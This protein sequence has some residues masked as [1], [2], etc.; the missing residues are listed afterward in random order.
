M[1][2]RNIIEHYEKSNI[3]SN[4]YNNLS[5]V[6]N[7]IVG[8]SRNTGGEFPLL[9]N[10]EISNVRNKAY[11]NNLLNER[12]KAWRGAVYNGLKYYGLNSKATRWAYCNRSFQ[13]FTCECGKVAYKHSGCKLRTCPDCS[14]K[15][16]LKLFYRIKPFLNNVSNTRG[17]EYSFKHIVLT[18]KVDTLNIDVNNCF[19]QLK[20]VNLYLKKKYADK[21]RRVKYSA[22]IGF[23]IGKGR[24]C[25]FHIIAYIPFINKQELEKSWA[26]GFSWIEQLNTEQDISK[27][28]YNTCLYVIGFKGKSGLLPEP[29][30]LSRLEYLLT[31]KRRVI[32]WGSW[33]NIKRIVKKFILICPVLHR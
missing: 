5:L 11:N 24:N 33:Y 22:L 2:N 31:G 23:E 29:Y 3:F 17:A 7:N 9:D 1:L 6:D 32:L 4:A 8:N 18:C 14:K 15:A 26:L 13:A 25:H 16:S 20:K 21:N 12:L 19:K 10:I 28:L 27:A 30:L